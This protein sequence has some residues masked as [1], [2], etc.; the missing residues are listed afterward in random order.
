MF[1]AH[2]WTAPLGFLATSAFVDEQ[3]RGVVF[4]GKQNRRA[5]AWIEQSKRRVR[6]RSGLADIYPLG[7]AQEPSADDLRC[8]RM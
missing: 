3:Q 2:F 8:I 4:L 1:L 5:F 6:L 7:Q